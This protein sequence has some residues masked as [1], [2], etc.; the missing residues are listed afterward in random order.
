MCHNYLFENVAGCRFFDRIIDRNRDELAAF[1]DIA[2]ARIRGLV[3]CTSTEGVGVGKRRRA[4]K[5]AQRGQSE[6]TG[7][8][9]RQPR[10]SKAKQE[11][12]MEKGTTRGNE[13]LSDAI[14]QYKASLAT[15][16]KITGKVTEEDDKLWVVCKSSVGSPISIEFKRRR[17]A[18]SAATRRRRNRNRV[19][20]RQRRLHRDRRRRRGPRRRSAAWL[21]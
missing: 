1:L 20:K 4:D 10:R 9:T 2:G 11:R 13:K 3:E 8:M 19:G 15:G 6:V 17:R 16:A 18:R 21:A 7:F 14:D 12:T 5:Q